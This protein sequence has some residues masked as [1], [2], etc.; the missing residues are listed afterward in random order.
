MIYL[1]VH[2][3]DAHTS[4]FSRIGLGLFWTSGPRVDAREFPTRAAAAKVLVGA[5]KNREGWRVISAPALA[6][7]VAF[8]TFAADAIY[9]AIGMNGTPTRWDNGVETFFASLCRPE[10]NLPAR[11]H[12]QLSPFDRVGN[13]R[14][15]K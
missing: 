5:R 6:T 10:F 13:R 1:I 7:D 4:Y 3:D 11:L 2:E 14:L 12:V 15:L 9:Y 8:L